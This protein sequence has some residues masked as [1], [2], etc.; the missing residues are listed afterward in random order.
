MIETK[1]IAAFHSSAIGGH[2]GA[3][4]TRLKRLVVW[5]AFMDSFVTQYQIYQHAKHS[6]QRLTGILR[7]LPI[8]QGM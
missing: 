5:K 3:H 8:N 7:L 1:I 6:H 2:L 4:A